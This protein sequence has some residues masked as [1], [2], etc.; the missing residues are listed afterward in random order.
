MLPCPLLVPN[1]NQAQHPSPS[2]NIKK[3]N[4]PSVST[5]GISKRQAQDAR[6]THLDTLQEIKKQPLSKKQE[7]EKERKQAELEEKHQKDVEVAKQALTEQATKT[8]TVTNFP[9]N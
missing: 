6:K 5:R 8:K 9:N 1:I 7:C 4:C 2:P 3:I